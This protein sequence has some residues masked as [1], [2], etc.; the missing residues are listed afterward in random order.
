MD[1]LDYLQESIERTPPIMFR[2]ITQD[3]CKVCLTPMESQHLEKGLCL[4]CD[5]SELRKEMS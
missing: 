2:A 5:M 3:R 4:E 1:Q